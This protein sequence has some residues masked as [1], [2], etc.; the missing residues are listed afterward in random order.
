MNLFSFNRKYSYRTGK[1]TDWRIKTTGSRWGARSM[2]GEETQR[3]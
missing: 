3:G 1:E 2:G